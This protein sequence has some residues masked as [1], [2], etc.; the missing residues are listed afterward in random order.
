MKMY[1]MQKKSITWFGAVP[2]SK[3]HSN[4]CAYY[5]QTALKC[6]STHNMWYLQ[7]KSRESTL[8]A[9]LNPKST[10]WSCSGYLELLPH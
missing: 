1:I 8:G 4:N 2:T 5:P 7:V 9:Q 6:S 10:V 3:F